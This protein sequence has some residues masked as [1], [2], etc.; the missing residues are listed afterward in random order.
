MGG[1]GVGGGGTGGGPIT[2]SDATANVTRYDVAFDLATAHA[3]TKLTSTIVT[4]GDCWTV[5]DELATASNVTWN[6][7]PASKSEIQNGALHACG[8]DKLAAGD[9]LTLVAETDVMPKTY[10]NLDVGFS[11]KKDLAGGTFTYLLSWVGGCDRFG[12]CDDDPSRFAEFHFDVAH[13]MNDVVLCPGKLTAGATSTK[14]DLA[15]TLAPTYSAFG[16]ASDPLWKRAPVITGGSL[17]VTFYEVPGGKLQAA[18]D[19]ASFTDYLTWIQGLLGP[20]PYGNEL[21]VAGG[22]TE[23]LGFE[24]PANIILYEKLETVSMPYPSPMQHVLMHETAHQW[25]GDRASLK[26]A[27]DFVWKEATV[28]YLSYVFED[29]QR[30]VG[31]A[32]ASR[33]Y[34][35]V[36]ALQAQ[37]RPRPTDDPPLAVNKF[38]GDVYTAGPMVLYVQLESM[39]GRK[40]VLDGVKAF[41]KQPGAKSVD[42]LQ[43]ALEQ[44]SG[45]KLGPYFTAW[46][47]GKGKPEWPTFKLATQVANGQ[48]TVSATQMNASG[49][50]YPCQ[51][52]VQVNGATESALVTVDFGLDPKAAMAQAMAAFPEPVVS[53]VLDPNHKLIARQMNVASP[54]PVH[55]YIF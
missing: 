5:S 36:G 17:D 15:G 31:E 37:H 23:W 29:E 50:I 55:V 48:V 2:H 20:F 33:A 43:A 45:A 26:S 47:N 46:V 28:E 12:P 21:R 51:V 8:G 42:D 19:V 41:L 25:S 24:H 10:F 40:A 30:P 16:L 44:A 22:P 38:Y 13:A 53:T 35:D 18:L 27:L 34:W 4:P 1:G 6:G 54:P 49:V 39:L 11:K 9:M 3:S 14:C 32:A 7:V 52:E